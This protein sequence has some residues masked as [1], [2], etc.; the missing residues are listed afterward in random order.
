M[1]ITL[2]R[3]PMILENKFSELLGMLKPILHAEQFASKLIL[4]SNFTTNLLIINHANVLRWFLDLELKRDLIMPT[5][6]DT[7]LHVVR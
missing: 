1:G 2:K 5:R 4:I 7:L 3:L 6:L